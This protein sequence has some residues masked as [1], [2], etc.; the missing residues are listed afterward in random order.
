M[1]AETS[2]AIVRT[3]IAAYLGGTLNTESELYQGGTLTQY[4]MGAVST[5][6]VKRIGMQQMM[7][8]AAGTS[9]GALVVVAF[10]A[11]NEVHRSMAGLPVVEG[12]SIVSGG[13]ELITYRILLDGYFMAQKAYA[14]AA[15][16]ALDNLIEQTKNQ[17]RVD[18]T[19]GGI[20]L[21]AGKTPFGI[22]TTDGH[23]G[24][25][26]NDRVGIWFT[27]RFEAQV[28]IIA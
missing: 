14:Q 9:Y 2:R 17:I 13:H 27:I 21:N 8:A 23:P 16:L 25:D 4:G 28:D 19:L 1:T 3:G 18:P 22:K 24:M 12:G 7:K 11:D 20:V 5:G 26:D 10:D 15:E 6:Y